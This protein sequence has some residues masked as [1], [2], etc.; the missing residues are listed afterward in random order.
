MAGTQESEISGGRQGPKLT[1]RER[2]S[3]GSL[4]RRASDRTKKRVYRFRVR[5]EGERRA[6]RPPCLSLGDD[7]RST[8]ESGDV[9][10]AIFITSVSSSESLSL[11]LI[12]SYTSADHQALE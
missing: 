10:L 9:S 5:F 6:S 8:T 11:L 1:P 4:E 12:A 2:D 3:R 7:R